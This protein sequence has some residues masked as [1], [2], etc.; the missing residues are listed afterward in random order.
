MAS[1][2]PVCKDPVGVAA[3]G[4]EVAPTCTDPLSPE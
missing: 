3:R 2:V 1:L 4:Q